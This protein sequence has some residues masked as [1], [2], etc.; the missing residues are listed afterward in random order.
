MDQIMTT[1]P[2]TATSVNSALSLPYS[3]YVVDLGKVQIISSL[4]IEFTKQCHS[5]D[6]VA[7][8]KGKI[9]D[10]VDRSKL[11]VFSPHPTIFL[12][13]GS[14]SGMYQ[15]QISQLRLQRFSPELQ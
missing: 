7:K 1:G 14:A 10:D 5:D 4:S 15:S 11:E 12:C 3:Y 13:R 6:V 9:N 8:P 2:I